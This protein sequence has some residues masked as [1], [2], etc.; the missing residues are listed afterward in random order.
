M[1]KF[2]NARH[3]MI[4]NIM[5]LIV[6]VSIILL[7]NWIRDIYKSLEKRGVT[8]ES[9]GLKDAFRQI[10]ARINDIQTI[11]IE[12][13]KAIKE[14]R[15]KYGEYAAH[16]MS[17][18]KSIDTEKKKIDKLQ[19]VISEKIETISASGTSDVSKRALSSLAE[20]LDFILDK[21]KVHDDQLV[22]IQKIVSK[23]REDID[24]LKDG[25]SKIPKAEIDKVYETISKDK[26]L[27]AS[28]SERTD[29]MQ[30][31][32]SEQSEQIEILQKIFEDI[33]ADLIEMDKYFKSLSKTH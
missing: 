3:E 12:L 9:K 17:V 6:G 30:E 10:N 4:Y 15:N 27:I 26:N 1:L 33:D 29:T 16:V 20:K 19:E 14:I 32:I 31:K 7:V 25:I 18:E 28:L 5:L 21:F 11:I 22:N 2:L 23:S 24:N 13:D 8:D